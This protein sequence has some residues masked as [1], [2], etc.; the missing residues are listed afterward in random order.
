MSD[1][2]TD[3]PGLELVL[4]NLIVNAVHAAGHDGWVRV[5][6]SWVGEGW[7]FAVEDSGS[8][9]AADVL[10][11]I[12]EPFFTTKPEGQGTGLGLAVSLGIVQRLGGTLRAEPGGDGRGARFVVR[13]P[14][15]ANAPAKRV[16][17]L[18]EPT[19]PALDGGGQPRVLLVDDERSIRLALGRYMR[20]NGWEVDEAEDGAV[21]LGKL[22]AS[23]PEGYDLVIT[24]LRMPVLSGFE[25]HDWLAVHRP[26]LFA[27]LIIATGDVAS[28]P[29]REFL[30]RTPRPVLEKP[31]ELAALAELVGRV[32]RK[33]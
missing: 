2:L 6:G 13:I 30:D 8:G 33:G 23:S 29:V 14:P 7:Q 10:P 27:R 4:T 25:V 21:A 5:D 3:A 31:F 28:Q 18:P 26:D 24:D 16:T 12:F 11:R 1:I 17:A 32:R 15:S 9:I 22:D 20:R 19:G